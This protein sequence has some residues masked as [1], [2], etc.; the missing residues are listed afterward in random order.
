MLPHTDDIACGLEISVADYRNVECLDH[1]GDLVPT[2]L[3]GKHLG[4]GAGMQGK[5]PGAGVL[6]PQRDA[7]GVA[8]LI[9]PAAPGLHRYR[10]MGGA[11]DCAND[12]HHQIKIPKAAGSAVPLH[13][14]F[15]RAAE[16]DV[17]ELRLI[18][19]GDETRGLRHGVGI[20]TVD[21]NS[22]RSLDLLELRPFERRPDP[23]ADR[24]GGEELGEHEVR[25]HA[26]AD[27]AE[28][29]LGHSGHRRQNEREVGRG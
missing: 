25:A 24:F 15:H 17:D 8:G 14:L 2:G 27:L 23:A 10:Q 16:V 11:D 13:Y 3:A 6:H 4:S 12:P 1:L 18:V 9:V 21:L 28:W 29:R 20:R 19:L 7:H 5:R 26:P 22:D